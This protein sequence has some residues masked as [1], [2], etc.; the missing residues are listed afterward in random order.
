MGKE[1]SSAH[2][3]KKRCHQLIDHYA[4]LN[5]Q[6]KYKNLKPALAAVN[7]IMTSELNG[8]SGFITDL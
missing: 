3:L 2:E 8:M 1:N 5:F 6:I 7:Q 4:P